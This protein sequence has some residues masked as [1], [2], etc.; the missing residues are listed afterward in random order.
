VE[1]LE[2]GVTVAVAWTTPPTTRSSAYPVAHELGLAVH[3]STAD[4]GPTAGR[5]ATV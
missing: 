5:S 2:A 1:V 3:V 4:G